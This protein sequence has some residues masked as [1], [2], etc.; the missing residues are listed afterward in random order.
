MYNKYLTKILLFLENFSANIKYSK[1][2]NIHR[3]KK[4]Y[5]QRTFISI[6]NGLRL[7]HWR[8]IQ[9][10]LVKCLYELFPKSKSKTNWLVHIFP[11]Q[12][13]ISPEFLKNFEWRNEPWRCMTRQQNAN[14]F[15]LSFE[16]RIERF[17]SI[18]EKNNKGNHYPFTF[19]NGIENFFWK[20]R[21]FDSSTFVAIS[22]QY[23]RRCGI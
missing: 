3:R 23:L 2:R 9:T 17:R 14:F 15:H 20:K 5:P 7:F 6:N 16:K 8:E 22:L 1:S 18:G 11:S 4:L 13:L 10:N 21:T 19:W 12:I